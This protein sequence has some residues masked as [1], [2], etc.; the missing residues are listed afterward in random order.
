M[1]STFNLET[2]INFLAS[3]GNRY[4]GVE[5]SKSLTHTEDTPSHYTISRWVRDQTFSPSDLWN[6]VETQVGTN[7]VLILDDS[8]NAGH[9][10]IHSRQYT[11]VVMSITSFVVYLS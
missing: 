10:R 11:G 2:Y 8:T 4:S 5:A 3:N 6:H 7:D 9:P 1:T